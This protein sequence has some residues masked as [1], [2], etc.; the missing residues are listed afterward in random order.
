MVRCK[1][2][3]EV[4]CNTRRRETHYSI[5]NVAHSLN[6]QCL[7]GL[8]IQG[9]FIV[10]RLQMHWFVANQLKNQ[11]TVSYTCCMM[12]PNNLFGRLKRVSFPSEICDK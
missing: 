6:F 1:E 11:R 3:L 7:R 5:R 9:A 2:I 12:M 8:H 10:D 4:D